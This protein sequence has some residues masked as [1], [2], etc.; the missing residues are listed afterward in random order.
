MISIDILSGDPFWT[1]IIYDLSIRD[2]Y[3][4]ELTHS[5]FKN[6]ARKR[7]QVEITKKII[8]CYGQEDY[9]KFREITQQADIYITG[10]IVEEIFDVTNAPVFSSKLCL[11]G[12]EEE[13][14][15]IVSLYYKYYLDHD[16]DFLNQKMTHINCEFTKNSRKKFLSVSKNETPKCIFKMLTRHG[17]HI[18]VIQL[19]WLYE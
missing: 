19:Q 4:L 3:N 18:Y 5:Y 6:A 9:C 10:K 11:Y 15:K 16:G 8:A 1:T 7:L 13:I 17:D 12:R 14:Q 2:C